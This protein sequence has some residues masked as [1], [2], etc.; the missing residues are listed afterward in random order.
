MAPASTSG[1]TGQPLRIGIPWRTT[2]EQEQGERRKLDYYFASVRKAGAEPVDIRLDAS[3]AA[4]RAQ[5]TDLDGFILPGSPADVDPDR[6]LSPKHP[7]TSDID[8]NRESTDSAILDHAFQAEKPVLAIC[9]G[10]QMLNVYQKGSLIQDLKSERPETLAHG[11]TDLPPGSKRGDIQHP[12]E[13]VSGSLLARLNGGTVGAINSSHHQAIDK[14]GNSLAVTAHA[15]DGTIEAVEWT[16]GPNWVV[17]VQ[18]HP[19][20]MPDD[21]LAQK[22]FAEFVAA[23]DRARSAR[24]SLV[25]KA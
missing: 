11:D 25:Q 17:G 1:N 19:E 3:V 2:A 14:P 16:G 10:C 18:W 13:F 21:A 6:Y 20:R 12:A 8:P 15:P 23:A 24:D 22:L 7:K 9:F 4:I 5:I